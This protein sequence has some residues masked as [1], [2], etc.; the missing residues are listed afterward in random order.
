MADN[1]IHKRSL[2]LGKVPTTTDLGV[3]QIAINVPDGKVFL[4][5]SGSGTDTIQTLV[6]TNTL[7]SGSVTISG[8]VIITGSLNVT[9]GITGSLYGT[10]SYAITA[11]YSQN[12]TSASYALSSSYSVSSSYSI[13]SSH[14][15]FAETATISD[16]TTQID[17]YVINKSGY[18]I[19]KG[20]VVRLTGSDNSGAEPRIVSASYENDNNSANT[21][22]LAL[23]AINNNANGYIITQG[24]LTG[25]DTSAFEEGQI[26]YLGA[27]GSITGSA[28]LAPLHSVRIGEVVRKQLNAGSI[29]VRIDNG[30]ELGELHDVRDTT[31]TSSYGDLLIR[32]GSVWT[33]SKNLTGS[34][35]LSGSL[36]TNDGVWVQ[37]LTASVVSASQF[38]GSLFGTSS[39]ASNA[40]TSSYILNAES[41]SFASTAS[42]VQTAQTASYVL[43]A[44]SASFSS[45]ASYV[46]GQIFTS[47][48]PVLSSSYALTAS[49]AIT[50]AGG[51]GTGAGFPFSGSAVITGSLIVTGSATFTDSIVIDAILMTSSLVSTGVG[52]TVL[53][54]QATGSYRSMFTKYVASST[55]NARAG[56]FMAV[57][58]AGNIQFT[59]TSTTDIGDTSGVV[60]TG[61]LTATSVQLST[62]VGIGW[63]IKTQTIFV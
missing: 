8:S 24:L 19:P 40:I 43:Q 1:I 6:A 15:I 41:S 13:T 34:Y 38:T 14:A 17:A 32:S 4:R 16:S 33:N 36:T 61:S 25:I 7:N 3:G 23:T 47:A 50:S 52:N 21:I 55:T 27:N 37:T 22:G 54:T 9:D 20:M 49:Y 51:G 44:V 53:L 18:N 57:W 31:T 59:D 42:Y 30:Y 35:T 12:S 60:L 10:S 39:W 56:E 11:S 62:G 28:P 63:T 58:N 5:Q 29:Y 46:D 2:T 45:T 26:V 48:N